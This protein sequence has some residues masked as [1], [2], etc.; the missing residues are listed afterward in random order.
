MRDETFSILVVL[1]VCGVIAIAG[2]AIL[3]IVAYVSMP[4]LVATNTCDCGCDALRDDVGRL[5][6][7]VIV[8][9]ANQERCQWMEKAIEKE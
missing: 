1:G 6:R 9:K 5:K 2:I 3:V 4:S 7:D 8:L